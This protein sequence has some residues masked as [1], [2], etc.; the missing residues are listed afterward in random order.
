M[1]PQ[2]AVGHQTL[3][4]VSTTSV[5]ARRAGLLDGAGA[6]PR[7]DGH[8]AAMAGGCRRDGG[9]HPRG[10]GTHRPARALSVRVRAGAA[11]LLGDGRGPPRARGG[12]PLVN[13]VKRN[14]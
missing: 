2:R 9:G 13:F 10:G 3:D 6:G 5:H 1:A 12:D 8:R 14:F 11:D 4:A 7:G